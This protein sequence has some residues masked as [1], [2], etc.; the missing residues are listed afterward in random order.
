MELRDIEI[1]LALA[2]EL[3]FGRTAERL[4]I[5]QA[6]VS[7]AIAKQERRIGAALFERTS[8]RVVLTPIGARLREDLE[9]GYSRIREGLETA[10]TAARGTHGILTLGTMGALAHDIA[11]VTA[12]FTSRYPSCEL[13]FRETRI[14]DPF[15]QLR[16]GEVDLALIWLPVREPDLTVGPVLRARP[17]VLLVGACHPLA[18]RSSVRMEDLGDC[19]VLMPSGPVPDYW[20]EALVP[21]RTP[22][23][24]PVPRGPRVATWQEGLA[25]VARGQFVTPVQAEAALYYRWPDLVYLPIQ[26]APLGE[27]AL[28]WRTAGETALLRAFVQSAQD[29]LDEQAAA[30][31]PGAS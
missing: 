30:S 9:A 11:D 15:R 19:T 10:A 6:R 31:A 20:Y 4:H 14:G 5:S 3:H 2:E 29:T 13:R 12:R 18:R 27:W 1:F 16:S 8:R 17:L 7:Q 25:A 22:G 24:R 23:G 21:I 28:V 26:D